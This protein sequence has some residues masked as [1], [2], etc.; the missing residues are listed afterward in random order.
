MDPPDFNLDALG[1]ILGSLSEEDFK[2]ISAFAQSFSNE[3]TDNKN[4]PR[5]EESSGFSIDPEMLLRLMS[6][7]EK[8]NSNRNDPRCNLISALK[9]LLS[10]PRQKKADQAIE[11]MKIFSLLSDG[12]IFGFQ[13]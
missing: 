9:P 5:E 7:F 8:L 10:P 2:N 4:E 1:D 6:I 11:M 12:S 13:G 3:S